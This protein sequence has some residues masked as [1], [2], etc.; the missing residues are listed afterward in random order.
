METVAYELRVHDPGVVTRHPLA[1]N[2]NAEETT[3]GQVS[4]VNTPLTHGQALGAIMAADPSLSRDAVNMIAAQS[5]VE[6][7]G[8]T[9]MHNNNMGNVTPTGSQASS[10][11]W[12]DQ[13]LP[14]KYISYPD[15]VSGAVGMLGWLRSHGLLAAATDADLSS[16]M[17][18]LQAGCYLGCIGLTDPTGHTVSQDDYM[19]YQNG[20]A[21]WIR[22]LQNVTPETP[23]GGSSWWTKALGVAAGV[24]VALGGAYA[25]ERYVA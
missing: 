15:A 22:K 1:V 14:M 2:D 7:A 9:A 13:G 24:A 10:G 20:I 19:N 5:A 11:D 17:T 25:A 3:G 18:G 4:T 8:W 23:P 12:M 16:Y 6:T 21:S